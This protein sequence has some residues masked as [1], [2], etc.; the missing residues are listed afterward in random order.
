MIQYCNIRF[1]EILT[2]VFPPTLPI[3]FSITGTIALIRLRRKDI[4]GTNIDKIHIS[5][6]IQT[7]CFD[8]TGTLT[9]I[10]LKVQ[11]VW[12]PNEKYQVE[13]EL[14]IAT[15]HHLVKIDDELYG[16]IL[17]MEMYSFSQATLSYPEDCKF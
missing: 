15:A 13:A 10:G 7:I 1:I 12:I 3:F 4:L 11:D 17:D 16:D 14:V 9:T 8:K 6:G 2:W 5:G